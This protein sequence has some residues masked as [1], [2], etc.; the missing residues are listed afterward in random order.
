MRE[1]MSKRRNSARLAVDSAGWAGTIFTNQS[2]MKCLRHHTQQQRRFCQFWF[3]ELI[4]ISTN[5]EFLA[6]GIQRGMTAP[7]RSRS[8]S[9]AVNQSDATS[10]ASGD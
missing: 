2:P 4:G 10:R 6:D 7:E 9:D 5:S 8:S 3:N 1:S